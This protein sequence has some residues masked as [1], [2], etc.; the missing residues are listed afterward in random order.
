MKKL[1][2]LLLINSSIFAQEF[3]GTILDLDSGRIQ[4]IDGGLT[5]NAWEPY[6]RPTISYD[7]MCSEIA[8]S[9]RSLR[10]EFL[11]RQQIIELQEQTELLR[12]I[13]NQ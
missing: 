10:Q 4:V 12:K 2:L 5:K 6:E 11:A 8:A 3:D 13:A 7:Q 9:T 1:L